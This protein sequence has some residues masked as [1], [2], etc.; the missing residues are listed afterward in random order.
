[1]QAYTFEKVLY[2][3]IYLFPNFPFPGWTALYLKYMYMYVSKQDG[4][5]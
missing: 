4:F 2:L 1:M 5:F 3:F